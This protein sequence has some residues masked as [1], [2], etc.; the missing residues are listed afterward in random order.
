MTELCDIISAFFIELFNYTIS[1]VL[2]LLFFDVIHTAHN[3]L[4]LISL[5]C[6]IITSFKPLVSKFL[7]FYEPS[8]LIIQA[9]L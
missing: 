4:S 8:K 3:A 9:L 6:V 7:C 1:I 5:V 2:E